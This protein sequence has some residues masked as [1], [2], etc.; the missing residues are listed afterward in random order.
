MKRLISVLLFLTLCFSL[1]S[2]G[3][4][5]SSSLDK[6]L[7]EEFYSQLHG[8]W[9]TYHED[10]G[11]YSYIDVRKIDGRVN[12]SLGVPMTEFSLGGK[13]TSIWKADEGYTI[14]VSIPA[15][16]ATEESDGHSAYNLAVSIDTTKLSEGVLRANDFAR[17]GSMAD[18]TFYC[19]VTDTVDFGALYA[20]NETISGLDT[21]LAEQVWSLLSGVWMLTDVP[22]EV[23]FTAFE[24]N[25]G[26]YTIVQGIPDSGYALGGTLTDIS[27]GGGEYKM[28]LYCPAVPETEMDSGHEAYYLD[29][30]LLVLGN[31][32]ISFTWY[33]G[34]NTLENW[35][36]ASES[37]DTFNW[38]EFY[39]DNIDSAW[40]KLS[41]VWVGKAETGDVLFAYFYV[42]GKGEHMITLGVPFSE[43]SCS[44]RAYDFE[45]QKYEEDWWMWVD[46]QDPAKTLLILIDYGEMY[47]NKIRMTDF[48]GTGKVVTFEYKCEDLTHLTVEMCA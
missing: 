30:E 36:F 14:V 19:D 1:C 28:T 25:D 48:F 29:L 3:S 46:V 34:N 17:D 39:A 11:Y 16:D 15:A 23:F 33:A 26:E 24:E 47:N 31:G 41:G 5:E 22:D 27:G 35:Q 10:T 4:S 6:K 37:L 32:K 42:N 9:V 45:D 2:C 20:G 13:I 21:A 7:L 18:Y 8:V 43:G 40:S 12:F 38:I 44:A